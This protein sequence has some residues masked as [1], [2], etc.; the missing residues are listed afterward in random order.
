[1][2]KLSFLLLDA[3]VVIELFEHGIWD[4]VVTRCDIYIARSVAREASFYEKDGQRHVIDLQVDADAQRIRVFDLT[5]A[6]LEV[7]RDTFDPSY[8]ER[9]D[10][11][12]TESL[13]YLLRAPGEH[14]LCSADSIVFKV[15]GNLDRAEQGISLEEVLQHVGLGRKLP[16][17]FTKAFR[18]QY[19]AEGF[20][21]GLWGRGK[22]RP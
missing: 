1:M 18:D 16:R 4:G 10:P 9:L 22:R 21:D 12:E 2:K 15:L 20:K 5:T 8:M 19:T 7:F 3:N 17:Q 11:G 14:R 13:L 6:D